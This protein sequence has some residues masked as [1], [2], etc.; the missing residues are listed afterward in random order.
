MCMYLTKELQNTWINADR[1]ERRIR[2][3]H[4]YSRGLQGSSL[5]NGQN[6]PTEN[7]KYAAEL[8]YSI[9]QLEKVDIYRTLYPTRT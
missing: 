9:Y 4:N 2:Q 5:S 1:I 6:E 7:H 8:N 3:I